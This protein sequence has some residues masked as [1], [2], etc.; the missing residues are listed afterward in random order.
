LGPVT[1]G[2][3][4][5]L[6]SME[7]WLNKVKEVKEGRTGKRLGNR[8]MGRKGDGTEEVDRSQWGILL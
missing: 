4:M 5:K 8:M 6:G 2:S 3:V 7:G 1:I